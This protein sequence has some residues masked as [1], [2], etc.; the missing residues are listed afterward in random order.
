MA[1]PDTWNV[2]LLLSYSWRSTGHI[3]RQIGRQTEYVRRRCKAL[4]HLG[5]LTHRGDNRARKWRATPKGLEALMRGPE[6]A[7]VLD[8][9]VRH[10]ITSEI[11]QV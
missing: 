4:Q 10:L 1:P 11:N 2:L 5:M 9:V 8:S 3:G 6:G 7:P